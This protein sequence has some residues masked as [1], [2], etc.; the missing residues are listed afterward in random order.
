MAYIGED[1]IV[2]Q[3]GI[4]N[5]VTMNDTWVYDLS[6]NTWTEMTPAT[7]PI[8]SYEPTM[9]YIGDDKVLYY[10]GIRSYLTIYYDQTW[11]YDLSDD[12]WTEVTPATKPQP[13]FG[14]EMAYIGN[15]EAI[16]FGGH[17][18]PANAGFKYTSQTWI[19][20]RDGNDWERQDDYTEPEQRQNTEMAFLENNKAML[21]GGYDW[22]YY[23][24][25]WKFDLNNGEWSELSINPNPVA[26]T[27]FGFAELGSGKV[28]L[29]G[30]V[31]ENGDKLDDT[32][33][34]DNGSNEWTEKNPT[35]GIPVRTN[36]AM[37]QIGEGKAIM[38]GGADNNGDPC[39]DTWLY[40]LT[41]NTWTNMNPENPPS[42]RAGH[43]MAKLTDDKVLMMG[44]GSLWNAG[45]WV[46]DLSENTW[47]EMAPETEPSLRNYFGMV[48]IRDK[49]VMVYGGAFV[50]DAGTAWI[51]GEE[52]N[53]WVGF[54]QDENP[55]EKWGFGIS[56]IADNKAIIFGGHNGSD[57]TWVFT[58]PQVSEAWVNGDY[59]PDCENDGHKWGIDAFSSVDEA[60]IILDEDGEIHIT[61]DVSD[62]DINTDQIQYILED[63]DLIITGEITGDGKIITK[64]KGYLK[65]HGSGTEENPL[66][67][68]IGDEENKWEVAIFWDGDDD[69]LIG[70]RVN[71]DDYYNLKSELGVIWNIIG[72]ENLD[73]TLTFKIPKT[74]SYNKIFNQFFL[75]KD[76]NGI[77]QEY[78]YDIDS[79]SDPDYYII[80]IR[81]VDEL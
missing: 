11:I 28:L 6:D 69:H 22:G 60:M 44:G 17:K 56:K 19:Y 14:G 73:A 78:E 76:D 32:W 77:W 54:E 33:V 27:S 20:D 36:F 74:K 26:R 61:G 58:L 13:L 79:E 15:N 40:D 23:A 52:V 80:T 25:T 2:L 53:A 46:Y 62:D 45:T 65:I 8:E 35:G 49:R 31:D 39:N 37:C 30:E 66:F 12:E 48:H 55:G 75:R 16:L 50:D 63:G 29:F 42:E 24:D 1:K 71:E 18:Y 68:P 51:Y 3:G 81:G 5:S 64:G 7:A 47:T 38:F 34:Y 4:R 57:E 41:T 10:G 43:S 21:F 70:I 72:S 9:T 67:F 59:C